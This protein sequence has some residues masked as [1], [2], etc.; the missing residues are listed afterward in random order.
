MCKCK[1]FTFTHLNFSDLHLYYYFV[2]FFKLHL[3]KARINT[4]QI[5]SLC[6]CFGSCK[7]IYHIPLMTISCCKS[8]SIRCEC[9]PKLNFI[10]LQLALKKNHNILYSQ[11]LAFSINLRLWLCYFKK[12]L[13][14]TFCLK[15]SLE[16]NFYY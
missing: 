14:S 12:Y 9:I 16:Y 2:F 11:T 5:H 10:I 1:S 8:I 7:C 3:H 4:C 13:K 15:P 6:K